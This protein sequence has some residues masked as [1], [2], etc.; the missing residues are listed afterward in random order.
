[1]HAGRLAELLGRWSSGSE[2]LYLKLAARLEGLVERGEIPAD[3]RLP[4]ERALAAELAVSRNTAVAAY[5]VLR[6]RGLVERRRGSG[7]FV[8]R[9]PRPGRGVV[10]EFNPMFLH[11]L[12]PVP[13]LIDLTCAAPPQPAYLAE[14]V[15]EAAVGDFGIGYHPSGIPALRQAIAD[16]YAAQGVPTD[17]AQI[18]VTSGAQQAI[19]LLAQLFLRPGDAVA[20]EEL[21]YPGALDAFRGGG[22]R[23]LGVPLTA[24]G[25]SV[26]HLAEVVVGAK[27]VYLVPAFQ[28]PTGSVLPP[29]AARRVVALCESHGVPLVDDHVLAD[30][31]LDGPRPAPLARHGSGVISVGSLSKL[32]WGGVRIGWVRADPRTAADLARL[33]AVA[34]LGTDVVA[35]AIGVALF[36]RFG[37]L[38]AERQAELR[39]RRDQVVRDLRAALPSW[40]FRT[41]PGGQTLWIRLPGADSRRFAQFALRYGVALLEGTSL[42]A[43]ESSGEHIR[44]PFTLPPEALSEAVRRLRKA[45]DDYP[46]AND[47]GLALS[48]AAATGEGDRH[49]TFPAERDDESA[50]RESPVRPGR[51]HLR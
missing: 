28:N 15:A 47:A 22:A 50:G 29:H 25:V 23:I 31:A 51:E 3:G 21:T 38:R 18:V 33:K 13:D 30:L 20:V 37:R 6:D 17:P 41:P 12:D 43:H 10:A 1:M 45:W 9:P 7:T 48:G 49:A 34:D 11:L 35:Q 27:L 46:G 8:R 32:I 36:A 5:D 4:T 39:A 26:P 16:H 24:D 19:S 14:V 2:P 40:E 42:A 44:V